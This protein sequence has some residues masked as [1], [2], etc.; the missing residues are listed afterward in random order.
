MTVSYCINHHQGVVIFLNSICIGIETQRSIS[1]ELLPDWPRE[2]KPF[3]LHVIHSNG[4]SAHRLK[5]DMDMRWH[6]NV[7]LV[8]FR[9]WYLL[10]LQDFVTMHLLSSSRI[11]QVVALKFNI[12]T[13]M[14]YTACKEKGFCMLLCIAPVQIT[15]SDVKVNVCV[16]AFLAIYNIYDIC[17]SGDCTN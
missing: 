17:H 14:L 7:L 15:L 1:D 5:L 10:F 9:T 6:E 13:G 16:S 2:A 12:W 3:A 4:A 8:R 11:A